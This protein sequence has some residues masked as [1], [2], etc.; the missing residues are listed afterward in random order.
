[1]KKGI[2]KERRGVF[3]LPVQYMAA[4]IIAGIAIG[5][6]S[7]A[8]YHMWKEMQRDAAVREVDRIVKEAAAMYATADE[9]TIQT[10][11]VD[12]PAG[13]KKAGFG[14]TGPDNAN[15]YY[16]LMDWG[17]NRSFYAKNANFSSNGCVLHEGIGRIKLELKEEGKKHVEIRAA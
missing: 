10:M 7:F 11:K 12:F 1:M 6:T 13:M 2:W 4:I 15:R 8:G 3:E 14:S 9:G 17:E 5:I 16:V